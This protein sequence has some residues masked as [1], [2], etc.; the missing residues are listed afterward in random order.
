MPGERLRRL[1][2]GVNA[3]GVERRPNKKDVYQRYIEQRRCLSKIYEY[4]LNY[5]CIMDAE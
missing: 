1:R 2:L 4:I 5:K 3:P